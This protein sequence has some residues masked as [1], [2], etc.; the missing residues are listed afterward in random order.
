M[1]QP[2]Y[3]LRGLVVLG[4]TGGVGCLAP[5]FIIG[6]IFVG[7]FL[8]N[9]FGTE[10]FLILTCILSGVVLSLVAMVGTA[11]RSARDV[12]RNASRP[13]TRPS[14]QQTEVTVHEDREDNP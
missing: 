6:A 14:T 11:L 3:D 5:I 8:D 2:G 1:R 4:G 13:L 12:Q 7:R 10:P 9:L